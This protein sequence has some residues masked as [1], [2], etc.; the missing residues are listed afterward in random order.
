[1]DS[2]LIPRVEMTVRP[3]TWLSGRCPDCVVQTPDQ[4]DSSGS[5]EDTPFMRA[6]N[7]VELSI[8]QNK[9]DETCICENYEDGDFPP[10][11]SNPER[12]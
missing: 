6:A 10:S 7:R 4:G 2:V 5:M 8:N 9:N 12:H 11:R 1:M 3:I